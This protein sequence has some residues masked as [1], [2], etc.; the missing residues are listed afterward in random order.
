MANILAAQNGNWSSVSTWTGGILPASGDNVYS[1]NKTVTIDVTVTATKI[2]NKAENSATA[3]GKF[4][5]SNGVILNANIE[6]NTSTCVDMVGNA[7]ATVNG[8]ITAGT[9]ST[10][11]GLDNTGS[12]IVTINGTITGGSS[13]V[14]SAPNYGEGVRNSGAGSIIVTGTV[15]AGTLNGNYGIFNASTGFITIN[16][17][18]YGGAIG[19]GARSVVNYGG[20]RITLNGSC[21]G[22]VAPAIYSETTSIGG[23]IMVNGDCYGASNAGASAA[24]IN[25]SPSDIYTI[26]GNCLG[27]TGSNN[28]QYAI[29]NSNNG[30]INI[31]GNCTGGYNPVSGTAA[32]KIAVINVSAGIINITGNIY[33]GPKTNTGVWSAAGQ[34]YGVNNSGNGTI[35]I[36]GDIYGSLSAAI[37]NNALGTINITGNSYITTTPL[38]YGSVN[39][40]STCISNASGG[41][42][43]I[44]GNV[45]G[46]DNITHTNSITVNNNSSGT[47]NI[48]GICYAGLSCSAVRNSSN[49]V[50]KATRAVGNI[51]GN[52]ATNGMILASYGVHSN[53][54]TSKTYI[55][56]IQFGSRGNTPINGVIY[57]IEESGLKVIMRK[58][59]NADNITLVDP[60]LSS[61]YPSG[62]NVRS[63]TVYAFGNLS[64]SCNVP[65]SNN[66]SLNIPVDSGI[67]TAVLTA[68]DFFNFNISGANANSIWSRLNNCATVETT[69]AQIAAA[70]SDD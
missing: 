43:N 11:R 26:Y 59:T 33:G 16:G 17:S 69:I 60:V 70:F 30:T 25:N 41:V 18:L 37:N 13:S 14:Q 5:L 54:I 64:G 58:D 46:S 51:Y 7:S 57:P 4:S 40:S 42:I 39:N 49:G 12:G 28:S 8:N 62:I 55:K 2:S 22:S 31:V 34:S 24:V 68:N 20:G 32:V 61:D 21:Y 52:P 1:N 36:T 35:N 66:V 9:T 48:V 67:G 45:Y 3:G 47:I 19:S 27:G 6:A 44:T 23:V 50:L 63:G 38:D 15:N 65:N 29:N 53:S 56:E 10:A